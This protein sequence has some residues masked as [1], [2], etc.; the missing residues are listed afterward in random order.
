MMPSSDSMDTNSSERIRWP[1]SNECVKGC[2]SSIIKVLRQYLTIEEELQI[3]KQFDDTWR[4]NNQ[5]MWGGMLRKD[6]QE[7]ADKHEMATLTTAM[8]PLMNPDDPLCLKKKKK[9]PGGWSK[10]IKGASAIFAWRISRGERVLVLSPP[11]PE[12]FHPSGRT[13]YQL[14][15]EPILKMGNNGSIRYE[16]NWSIR[17]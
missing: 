17:W 2:L 4:W 5:V 15:E 14:I 1:I 10:Y 13:D 7:W 3:C 11:P 12:R 6:A 9:S 16:S 8:G